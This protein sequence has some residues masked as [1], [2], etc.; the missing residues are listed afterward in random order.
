M[1]AERDLPIALGKVLVM[2]SS[3]SPFHPLWWRLRIQGGNRAI[4]L[5]RFSPKDISVV[6]SG[7]LGA[8]AI[9][10][11]SNNSAA[12]KQGRSP[13]ILPGLQPAGGL[14]VAHEAS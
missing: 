12:T 11:F 4:G 7:Q 13:W 9:G 14:A 10:A 8:A 6:Q 5:Q 3:D 1:V 2:R